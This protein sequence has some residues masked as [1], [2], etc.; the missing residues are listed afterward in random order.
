MNRDPKTEIYIRPVREIL[1]LLS[2]TTEDASRGVS[3]VRA[4][5][6]RLHQ[7]AAADAERPRH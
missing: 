1:E 2:T 4:D 5:R 7:E 6:P 3:R